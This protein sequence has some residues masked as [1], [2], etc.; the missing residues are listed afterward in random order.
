MNRRLVIILFTDMSF[1]DIPDGIRF[2]P[3]FAAVRFFCLY[4]TTVCLKCV[5][6]LAPVLMPVPPV[7]SRLQIL[8]IHKMID[9]IHK[10]VGI[11]HHSKMSS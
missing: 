7:P 11:Q 9:D 6:M 2:L 4:S 5:P 8:F 10:A 3:A 1:Y